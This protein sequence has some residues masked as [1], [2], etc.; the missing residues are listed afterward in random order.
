ME[1]GLLLSLLLVWLILISSCTKQK[2]INIADYQSVEIKE[3]NTP[4]QEDQKILPRSSTVPQLGNLCVGE[5]ECI[6]FCHDNRGRCVKYCQ[7][8]PENIFCLEFVPKSNTDDIESCGTRNV[9]FTYS[10]LKLEDFHGIVPLGN[11][12][13]T[14]HIY[15]T[16]H[17][18]FHVR[19]SD[20]N[21]PNSVPVEVP[22]VAPGDF[23][24]K[25]MKGIEV[26]NKPEYSSYND[27]YISFYP[28]KEFK[29]YFDHLKL[30]PKLKEAYD[31]G[32][33][34][35]EERCV[36]YSKFYKI[37]GELKF[38]VCSK[39]V[40]IEVKA[41]EHIGTAGGGFG[42]RVFDVGAFDRRISPHTFANPL[43]WEQVQGQ[44]MFYVVCAL[45]Y[46]SEDIKNSLKSRLGTDIGTTKRTKEPICGEVVQD[47]QNTAQGVWFLK[48]TT[49]T[50]HERGKPEDYHISLVP[51]NVQ[52]DKQVFAVGLSMQ[53][54]GL[55][56]GNYFF[57][58]K[59]SGTIDRDFKEVK[60]DENIYCYEVI[61]SSENK[62]PFVIILQMTT[63]TSLKIEK[64]DISLCSTSLKF[65][66]KFTEF[67][68]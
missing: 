11:L 51:D 58:P 34:D 28:C 1:K 30:S 3:S 42:Q 25:K 24:I 12:A 50:S 43:R 29:A 18:Y 63:P 35:P 67:E 56:F 26:I 21:N 57:V 6:S 27:Y 22:V 19:R 32:V 45:D 46:F 10:P 37:E 52:T 16:A 2:N 60:A 5:E 54:S 64:L 7:E 66:D 8:T 41:G 13:P 15:P 33:L 47:I 49:D 48:G 55:N 23:T 68:R 31:K 53:N 20:L 17:L 65:T 59:T 38:R 36:E 40:N 62:N 4:L 61:D 9:F 14:S 39:L 44:D